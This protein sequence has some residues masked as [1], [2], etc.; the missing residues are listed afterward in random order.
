MRSRRPSPEHQ[1]AVSRR[2]ALLSEQLASTRQEA[3]A[4]GDE[5]WGEHTRVAPLRPALHVVSPPLEEAVR[6]EPVREEPVRE[7]PATPWGELVPDRHHDPAPVMV[8]VPGRHADRRRL[9]WSAVLPETL[10]GRVALGPGPVAVV[11]VLVA[12]GLGWTCWQVVRDDPGPS[13]PVP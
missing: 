8:P 6:E 7:E 9:T 10:R 12:V 11:A 4:V 13:S 2:L 5:W 3:P 1:E